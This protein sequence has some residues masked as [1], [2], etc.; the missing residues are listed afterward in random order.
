MLRVSGVPDLLARR[1]KSGLVRENVVEIESIN[2]CSVCSVTCNIFSLQSPTPLPS[3][4]LVAAKFGPPSATTHNIQER[5][6][7]NEDW[8]GVK[9]F[10]LFTGRASIVRVVLDGGL[11]TARLGGNRNTFPV[12]GLS[13]L[14]CSLG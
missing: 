5:Y 14:L 12:F 2:L 10:M 9:M 13:L 7:A 8:R 11:S 6:N 4:F 3:F 1:D